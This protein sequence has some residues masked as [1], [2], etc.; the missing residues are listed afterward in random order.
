MS[1]IKNTDCIKWE[2]GGVALELDMQDVAVLERY[3]A[4]F[5]K[6]GETEKSLPKDGKASERVK[7]YCIMFRDL[8][9]DIFGE[10]TAEKIFG[11]TYNARISTEIYEDFLAFVDGQ[12]EYSSEVQ[13]RI[14]TR[15]GP[16]RA[17]RRA[18]AHGK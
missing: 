4:A 3:E 7:A 2:I 5:A 18:Q 9:D 11:S 15:F 16:N 8:F 1:Q 12:R 10:G 17:Q 13:N 6:M 14:V